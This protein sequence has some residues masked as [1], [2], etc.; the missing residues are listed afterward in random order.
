MLFFM[1]AACNV[2]VTYLERAWLWNLMQLCQSQGMHV[3]LPFPLFSLSLKSHF[4][5][6][7]KIDRQSLPLFCGSALF[8]AS[9]TWQYLL[10]RCS[11]SKINLCSDSG[12]ITQDFPKRGM[13]AKQYWT[14]IYTE[15]DALYYLSTWICLLHINKKVI[16]SNFFWSFLEWVPARSLIHY[17]FTLHLISQLPPSVDKPGVHTY[18]QPHRQQE[19]SLVIYTQKGNENDLF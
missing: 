1:Q 6:I 15:I 3:Q 10:G 4:Y 8:F 2:T 17:K 18:V 9:V 19:R 16:N 5:N 14:Y 13:S 12:V 11:F 7:S